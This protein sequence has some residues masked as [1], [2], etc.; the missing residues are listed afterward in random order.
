[1]RLFAAILLLATSAALFAENA[2]KPSEPL[3]DP[4]TILCL[5]VYWPF[6]GDENANA[7][8]SV[9]FKVAAISEEWRAGL[10]LL[11]IRPEHAPGKEQNPPDNLVPAFAGS[12]FDLL[13]DTEYEIELNLQDPDSGSMAKTLR[14]RTRAVPK[15]PASLRT[16]NVS[17]QNFAA[18]L[19]AAKA[20]DLLLLAPGMYKGPL[21]LAGKGTF[22]QPIVIRGEKRDEVIL[23]A[24]GEV[25]LYLSGEHVWFEHLTFRN[26]REALRANGIEGIVVRRCRF[27]KVPTAFKNTVSTQRSKDCYIA[28]N[29]FEHTCTFPAKDGIIEDEEAIQVVGSGHV[30]C[31]N[32]IKGF[33]DAVS[34]YRQ[35]AISVDIYNNEIDTATD[36]GVELDYGVRNLRCFRNR[37]TNARMG[38]SLQPVHCGPA[39]VFRNEIYNTEGHPFKLHN[40]PSGFFLFHNTSVRHGIPF[41]VYPQP[42]VKNA[43]LRNNLF[44]GTG[45]SLIDW[46]APAVNIDMD[47]DGFAPATERVRVA[48]QRCGSLQEA[49][50][51]GIEKNGRG[52]DG[53]LFAKEVP[54]PKDH[55]STLPAVEMD[56]LPGC[57][58]IDA[59]ARLPN[60]NDGFAG[61]APD[62]GA[63]EAS[64]PAPHFGPRPDGVDEASSAKL[65][66]SAKPAQS[67][68]PSAPGDQVAVKLSAPAVL[69]TKP[70]EPTADAKALAEKRAAEL[71]TSILKGVSGGKKLKAF[72]EFMGRPSEIQVLAGSEQGL[73]VSMGGE[74]EL[75][76]K[77]LTP[78]SLYNIA[79]EFSSDHEALRDYCRG[80]GLDVEAE[81]EEEARLAN[82]GKLEK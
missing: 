28:D 51:K 7:S 72:I 1:M 46:T 67:P 69:P 23:E 57:A 16:V 32:F 22:G 48:D 20:G 34:I 78:K 3:A 43:V 66:N 76:W 37:I 14:S 52:L 33:G 39:Y 64:L 4:P 21:H 8:V 45:D 26:C 2:I 73:K 54:V 17:P 10:P 81:R 62:I 11:R 79:R 56:L 80:N 36:D 63:R 42:P 41:S 15:A 25:A 27:D 9:R 70:A 59:G 19:Q 12:L 50:A 65:L 24:P 60:I 82:G 75:V 6:S 29:V 58:A 53:A 31:H 35:P 49:A 40:G 44:V 47:Y 38:I 77:M 55:K 5:G 74:V 30:I 68:K 61:A 18:A 13:P 71:K